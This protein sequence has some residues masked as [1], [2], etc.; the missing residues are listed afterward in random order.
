M[1]APEQSE[2]R[3]PGLP[4]CDPVHPLYR[5]MGAV[6]FCPWCDCLIRTTE[7]A[8]HLK[9]CDRRPSWLAIL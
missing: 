6:T 2:Q 3:H 4:C 8:T 9:V 5:R 1:T 7:R